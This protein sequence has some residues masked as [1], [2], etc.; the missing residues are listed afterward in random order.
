M[1]ALF[2]LGQHA[3]LKAIANEL[4]PTEKLCAFLD[5]VYL[6]CKPARVKYLY[7]RVAHHLHEH[8]GVSLNKGKTK[9]YNHGE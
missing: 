6:L 3:A 1:P 5:D 7:E 8:T 4:L 9:V 2:S